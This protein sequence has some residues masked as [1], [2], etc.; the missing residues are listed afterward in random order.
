MKLQPYLRIRY[1]LGVATNL[2]SVGLKYIKLTFLNILN[3]ILFS[4]FELGLKMKN[5][6]STILK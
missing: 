5:Q 2:I 1:I 3:P 4:Y 6:V